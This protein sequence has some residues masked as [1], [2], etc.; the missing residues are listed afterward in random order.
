MPSIS[1][2]TGVAPQRY[3]WRICIALHS[4][5]R[6]VVGFVYYNFYMSKLDVIAEKQKALFKRLVTVNFW[7][8]IVENAA[9]VGVTYIANV[10]NY[11]KFVF[12]KK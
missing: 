10:E 7:L 5:P 8:Y 6:F 1:G 2:I 11:R 12:Q 9:L 4:T 3:V